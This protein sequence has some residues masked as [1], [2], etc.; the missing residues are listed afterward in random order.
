MISK[1]VAMKTPNKSRFG[2]LVS[3]LVDQQGKNTRVGEVT[4][5]NCAS[6]ELSWAVR[7]IVATQ[8]LNTRAQSDRTYHLLISLRAGEHP[9]AQTLRAIE[10][11]F[12]NEL[13]YGEHQRVSVVHR[14]TDNLHIHV[15]INKIHPEH[16]T[17][18]DPKADYWVRSKLCAVLEHELG[19]A[20]DR[21]EAKE[22]HSPS[23]DMEARSGQ[24]SFRSWLAQYA[25]HFLD[26]TD[27][28]EFH[29]VADAY[30]VKLQ[31]RGNG[32]VFV[33]K[34]SG[35][36]AKA[37]DVH[38]RLAKPALESRLGKFV[39][40]EAIQ[41]KAEK[42]Y[43][44]TPLHRIDTQAL[45]REYT[46]ERDTRRALYTTRHAV[47]RAETAARIRAAK[48][49][50]A[51]R[52]FDAKLLFKGFARK[53]NC[54]AVNIALGRTIRDIYRHANQQ[55]QALAHETRQS[56][57]LDWLQCQAQNGRVDALQALRACRRSALAPKHLSP[58]NQSRDNTP[59]PP[60][61]QITKEGAIIETVAGH[62][63]RRDEAGIYVED[64]DGAPDEVLLA[65]L[66][67]ATTIFGSTLKTFG[68]E[69]FQLRLAKIA[70]LN[71][72]Q[73]HFD[74]PAI[75][76]V[77]VHSRAFSPVPISRAAQS[78]IGER[79]SK[80]GRMNDI[81]FHR[82]WNSSDTGE[83][84][85]SGLRVVD[86]Q[87]LLLVSNGSETIVLPI[88]PQQR[89]ELAP[90]PRGTR[91]TISSQLLIQTPVQGLEL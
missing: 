37:S 43:T 12:C 70:G 29:A 69:S 76:N 68:L 28:R 87:N 27:W 5:S 36:R 88:S 55:R 30:S 66:H 14:D 52:R 82:L 77:R 72:L 50:A 38:R 56:S 89:R 75:E 78:Y 44:K 41:A 35:V 58:A 63:I 32:F 80:R 19:L 4:I 17:I 74:D 65:V 71:H 23:N 91:L 1:K 16:L 22:R 67:H 25:Q 73:I 51:A 59:E 64:Q 33:H 7:E 11:R 31:I 79:N 86:N 26:A 21:H 54:F 90:I 62:A 34:E 18:H 40:A 49:D 3:Y 48:R 61:A 9:D 39:D 42:A 84:V 47:I 53:A 24:E 20:S 85:F 10:E 8:Q 15:A 13:G 83:F 46:A 57:W 81:P 60:G 6:T 2:K 45:W